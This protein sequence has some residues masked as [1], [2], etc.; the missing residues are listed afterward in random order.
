MQ[1]PCMTQTPVDDP[2]KPS[3]RVVEQRVRNRVIEY[4]ELAASFQEQ[5]EYERNAPIA[6]IPYEV[7]NQWEDWV[8]QDPREDPNSGRLR[9]GRGRSHGSVPCCMGRRGLCG[10]EQLPAAL[11]GPGAT[12]MASAPR[13]GRVSAVRLHEAGKD[14]EEDHEVES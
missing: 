12:R 8:H 5:Q 6:H 7:I 3:P 14:A 4:L 10:T 11:R 2:D 9:L 1:T 13:C